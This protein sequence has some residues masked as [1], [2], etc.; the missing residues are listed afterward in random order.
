MILTLIF[1]VITVLFSI[2][3]TLFGVTPKKRFNPNTNEFEYW[4]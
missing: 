1:F 2:F 3:G 4:K